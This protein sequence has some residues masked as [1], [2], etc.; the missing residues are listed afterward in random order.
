MDVERSTQDAVLGTNISCSYANELLER[1]KNY[2]GRISASCDCCNDKNC[3]HNAIHLKINGF[4]K[5]YAFNMLN[6]AMSDAGK[7]IMSDVQKER[8]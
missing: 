4:E 5:E 7:G 3:I 2:K 6:A 1:Y 8:T